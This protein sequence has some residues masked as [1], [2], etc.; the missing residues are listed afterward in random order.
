MPALN[1][2]IGGNAQPFKNE[3]EETIRLATRAGRKVQA[4]LAVNSSSMGTGVLRETL[5]ILREIGRGN[6]ARVPG[7]V[8]ILLSYLGVL[9]TA[10]SGAAATAKLLSDGYAKLAQAQALAAVAALRKAAASEIAFTMEEGETGA[11]LEGAIA[12]AAK[13]KSAQATAIAT[14]AKAEAAEAAAAAEATEAAATVGALGIIGSVVAGIVVGFGL[15]YWRVNRLT[16]S[17]SGI[18]LPDI[19]PEYIAKHLQRVNQVAEGWKK[20]RE[21][22]ERTIETYNSA[23]EAAKRQSDSTKEHYEHMRKMNPENK[24]AIDAEE[25]KVQLGNKYQEQFNLNREAEANNAKANSILSNIPSA[26]ADE[27]AVAIAKEKAAAARKEV[28]KAD[29]EKG[30]FKAWVAGSKG[31]VEDALIQKRMEASKLQQ[32]ANKAIDTQADND[33][34]RKEG[35]RLQSE[36][37]KSAAAAAKIAEDLPRLEKINKQRDA[38]EAAEDAAERARHSKMEH[39]HVNSLQAVGAFAANSVLVDV[40]RGMLHQLTEINKNTSRNNS[41][42]EHFMGVRH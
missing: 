22:V 23:A 29:T 20:I 41:H 4:S 16:E 3:L 11:T 1:V 30:G 37:A 12:D 35:E 27:N 36:A 17:L 42:N 6:W 24:E 13:A 33:E 7:S 34:K 28:E 10:Q 2:I 14:M 40:N 21:E 32:A 38:D 8:T 31:A 19:N 15:W 5:V 18:K 26:K 25:R 39:G 9:K